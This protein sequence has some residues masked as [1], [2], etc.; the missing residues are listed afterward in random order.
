MGNVVV[1]VDGAAFAVER[2]LGDGGSS[3]VLLVR[4]RRGR[5]GR[6]ALKWARGLAGREELARARLEVDV[7]RRLRHAHCLPLE[8]AEVREDRAAGVQG[9]EAVYE[10][11]LLF[12]VVPRGS[13]QAW[14][15]RAAAE[16]KRPDGG[17]RV[18]GA[19]D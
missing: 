17:G 13:L 10:A 19:G 15:E 2:A 14:L 11:L 4:G 9:E 3:R 1:R 7:Q 8:A 12:P 5:R 6:R 16:R 18:D